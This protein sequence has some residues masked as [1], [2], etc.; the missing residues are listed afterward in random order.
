MYGAKEKLGCVGLTNESTNAVLQA[1]KRNR[2]EQTPSAEEDAA[3]ASAAPPP[4]EDSA[5]A[6]AS[7]AGAPPSR[8]SRWESSSAGGGI[9][10]RSY[11]SQAPDLTPPPVVHSS[12]LTSIRESLPVFAYRQTLLDTIAGNPVTVVEGETGSGKTT[13]VPQF[14]IEDHAAKNLPCNVIVAQPRRIS[15]MSVAE[16]IAQERGE[17]IGGTV[18]YSIRLDSKKSRSTRLLFCTTGILLK[19]LEDDKDLQNVTHVF[20]DEVHE[21]GIE[22]DFLLMVMRDLLARRKEPCKLILMSATLDASLFHNYF[23]GAPSVKV[24]EREERGEQGTINSLDLF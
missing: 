22:T 19:R 6:A 4:E 11:P 24:R 23:G 1:L 3:A 17:Q 5:N 9:E 18:G 16:R 14:V 8:K 21:R 10:K 20:I 13:Q 7:A 12:P 2:A 15:A